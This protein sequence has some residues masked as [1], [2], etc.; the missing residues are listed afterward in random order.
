MSEKP[1][2]RAVCPSQ[3]AI[4]GGVSSAVIVIRCTQWDHLNG[5]HVG[6]IG[7]ETEEGRFESDVIWPM[8]PADSAHSGIES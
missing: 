8:A 5:K 4:K 3:A 2:S 7:V 6:K 1:P